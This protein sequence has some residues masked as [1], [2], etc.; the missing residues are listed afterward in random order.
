MDTIYK[1]AKK[2]SGENYDVTAEENDERRP[3]KAVLDIGLV[4][5]IG[6]RVFA[7]MKGA[8]DG[9]LNIPH[10]EGKFPGFEKGEKG[11]KDEYDAETHG[12]RIFGAHI[13]EYMEKLKKE[14]EEKYNKQFSLWIKNLKESGKKSVKDLF[15]SIF[16]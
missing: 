6:N 10:S 15:A 16:E 5:T 3:F 4:R 1:G 13:D 9:G 7:V 8:A 14:D 12:E 2:I 11:G